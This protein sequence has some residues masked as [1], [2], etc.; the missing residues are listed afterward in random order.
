MNALVSMSGVEKS[1]AGVPAL[2]QASLEIA[3]GEVHALIGQNGA[4]KST[5]IKVLTG[6]YTQ[7]DS[8]MLVPP[9][10]DDTNK[11]VRYDSV[12]ND[13]TKPDMYVVFSDHRSYVE[14]LVQYTC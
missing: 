1:F 3:P 7:G 6:V 4:G 13:V 2:S 11:A 10:R 12:V 14:Y 9:A 8:S 5:M